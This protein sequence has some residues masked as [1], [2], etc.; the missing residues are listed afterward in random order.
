VGCSVSLWL[1]DKVQPESF[2]VSLLAAIT[3]LCGSRLSSDQRLKEILCDVKLFLADKCSDALR[4]YTIDQAIHQSGQ[5][6][7]EV[8]ALG[9]IQF[10][11]CVY[12]EKAEH[13]SSMPIQS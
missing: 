5:A 13:H 3:Y 1:S 11:S 8:G 7:Q 10:K 2:N 9:C 12:G 6:Q 4:A